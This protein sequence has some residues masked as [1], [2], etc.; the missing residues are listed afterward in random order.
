M[1][2]CV[3]VVLLP[4]MLRFGTICVDATLNGLLERNSVVSSPKL[5]CME[6]NSCEYMLVVLYR[7]SL[8]SYFLWWRISV[9]DLLGRFT[10]A[11]FVIP[12][13]IQNAASEE[14][15]NRTISQS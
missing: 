2:S 12:F 15:F 8:R 3:I 13:A 14:R 1:L 6:Q 7:F 11:C 4:R 5:L 9:S 10:D